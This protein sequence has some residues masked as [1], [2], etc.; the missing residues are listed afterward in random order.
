MDALLRVLVPFAKRSLDE[1][2]TFFPFGASMAPDGEV[3]ALVGETSAQAPPADE[4]LELLYVGLRAR[5][6]A[7]ELLAAAIATDV[8]IPQGEW[9]EGIR[10]ELEH[11]DADP[12]TCVLPYREGDEGY[13]YG[14]LVALTGQRRTWD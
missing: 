8:T 7:G 9:R 5:A 1:H 4:V 10:V 6:A 14:T 2:G 13:D 3:E 12:I 11:R